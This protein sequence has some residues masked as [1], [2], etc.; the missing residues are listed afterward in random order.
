MRNCISSA[1]LACSMLSQAACCAAQTRSVFAHYITPMPFNSGDVSAISRGDY[2]PLAQNDIR[3]VM[4]AGLDGLAYNAFSGIA[5]KNTIL[6]WASAADAIGATNFRAFISF[7]MSSSTSSW[8]NI[9]AD[10]I[11]SAMLAVGNNPHYFKIN[12]RPVLS[13]YSGEALGDAWWKNN[14][15]QPLAA[16]GHPVTFLPNFDRAKPNETT[17]NLSNWTTVVKAYPSA[18]GLFSFGLP[19]S[20]PFYESDANIGNHKWSVLSGEE[21]LGAALDQASKIHMAPFIPTF[22]SVCHSARQYFE[23]SGG[24]GMDNFWKSIIEKQKPELVEIVTWNDY[25]ESSFISPTTYT[26]LPT[27]S[28]GI[29][30]Q[31]HIGY[32][33]LLKYYIS[34]YRRGVK[35]IIVKDSIF[36]FHRIQPM[37]ATI[38]G[39]SSAC[40]M[41]PVPNDQLWGKTEDM[42]YVTT[43]LTAPAELVVFSGNKK[44]NYYTIPAGLTT[45]KV[46]FSPGKQRF[47]VWRAS[48]NL[49]DV[50]SRDIL[51]S[52]TTDN[53]NV[54]SGYAVSGGISSRTWQPSDKYR[55][56]YRAEWFIAQ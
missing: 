33:E 48:K 24:L 51:A 11:V 18:N 36:Y 37:G 8:P 15:L 12:G 3:A 54:H 46:P 7:D 13:T 2:Q 4:E 16:A 56:G 42:I 25:T 47:Q 21:A 41:P 10:D 39:T 17:P 49:I 35:P 34:W 1:L 27:Q 50:A 22:W 31:T 23:T 20:P 52:P 43:A 5:A 26:P 45:T 6:S 55:T 53:Y 19:G 29:E 40:Q 32:Y 44:Y 9:R 30:T 14:V 28:A 38:N